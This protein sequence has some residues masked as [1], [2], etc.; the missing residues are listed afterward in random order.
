MYATPLGAIVSGNKF[1]GDTMNSIV[2]WLGMKSNAAGGFPALRSR[3]RL[4]AFVHGTS[5]P[6]RVRRTSPKVS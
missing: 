4:H 1:A 5:C 6:S 3:T 2:R